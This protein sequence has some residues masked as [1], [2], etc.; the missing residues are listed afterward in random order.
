[1]KLI[2]TEFDKVYEELNK[3][4]LTESN[5]RVADYY[6]ITNKVSFYYDENGYGYPWYNLSTSTKKSDAP[7]QDISG[8]YLIVNIQTNQAYVGKAANIARRIYDHKRAPNVADC[9][10]L[11]TAIKHWGA[12]FFK[13]TAIELM[14]TDI[15]GN[16]KLELEWFVEK[17][18]FWIKELHTYTDP[19]NYNLDIGGGNIPTLILHLDDKIKDI[20]AEL[21]NHPDLPFNKIAAKFHISD[22]SIVDINRGT[23][24]Y[25]KI[26]K[27]MGVTFPII[28]TN[29]DNLDTGTSG[30]NLNS[31]ETKWKTKLLH[32]PY[33]YVQIYYDEDKDIFEMN[34]FPT[35][36]HDRIP[37]GKTI[38]MI[39]QRR[40]QNGFD[41]VLDLDYNLKDIKNYIDKYKDTYIKAGKNN[42]YKIYRNRQ[43]KNYYF[44]VL[45]LKPEDKEWWKK[46]Y[47]SEIAKIKTN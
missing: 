35:S 15:F 3:C 6:A 13:Y 25:G 5:S 8:I 40:I 26:G 4:Y 44:L 11:H 29:P 10:F 33:Y 43:L 23:G 9:P 39:L 20:L 21:A 27:S 34:R 7:F 28:N 14:P 19:W 32:S 1:M 24:R 2:E 41:Q 37:N 38:E 42:L 16:E 31:S 17:E 22:R 36:L 46:A 12:K 47:N 45:K 30:W 18:K